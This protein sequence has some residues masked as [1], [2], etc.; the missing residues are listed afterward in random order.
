M[1][2]G[3]VRGGEVRG[4]EGKMRDGRSGILLQYFWGLD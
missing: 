4:G 3:E 2:S 1:G